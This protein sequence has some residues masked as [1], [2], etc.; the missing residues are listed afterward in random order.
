MVLQALPAWK[1]PGKKELN[2][3]I[4]DDQQDDAWESVKAIQLKILLGA[5]ISTSQRQVSC[6][7]LSP[8]S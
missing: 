8:M 5:H 3:D 2:V 7:L 4:T 1:K 6:R